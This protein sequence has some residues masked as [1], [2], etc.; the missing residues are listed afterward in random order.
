MFRWLLIF[1]FLANLLAFTLA[2][3]LLGSRPT[4]M[5]DPR[6]LSQQIHPEWLTV[7]P[8]AEKDALNQTVANEAIANTAVASA[9]SSVAAP[10]AS[11]SAPTTPASTPTP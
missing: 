11:A 2:S 9:A 3:G 5:P 1:L 8:I 6:Y 4:G 10:A 7:R